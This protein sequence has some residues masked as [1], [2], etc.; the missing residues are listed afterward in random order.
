MK[1]GARETLLC[2]LHSFDFFCCYFLFL[3]AHKNVNKTLKTVGCQTVLFFCVSG[4]DIL[5]F[6]VMRLYIYIR[7]NINI[8]LNTIAASQP[9]TGPLKPSHKVISVDSFKRINQIKYIKC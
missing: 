7:R 9:R 4:A 1:D 2:T 3:V 6:L 8:N 5:D